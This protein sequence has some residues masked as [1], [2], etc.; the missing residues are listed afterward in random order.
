MPNMPAIGTVEPWERKMHEVRTSALSSTL[1][2]HKLALRYAGAAQET[3][4]LQI[5]QCQGQRNLISFRGGQ[6]A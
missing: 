1:T 6:G 2:L 4:A 3:P 5:C